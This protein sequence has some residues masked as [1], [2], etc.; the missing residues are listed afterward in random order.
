M[1]GDIPVGLF[2][3]YSDPYSLVCS[4]FI[5]T[6]MPYYALYVHPGTFRKLSIISL[7]SFQ[8][9]SF[10]LLLYIVSLSLTCIYTCTL[11]WGFLEFFSLDFLLQ[12]SSTFPLF[13]IV[14]LINFGFPPAVCECSP[15]L[16]SCPYKQTI[17]SVYDYE[18][19][20]HYDTKELSIGSVPDYDK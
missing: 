16:G 14:P 19:N 5:W 2:S 12:V 6:P 13:P 20:C 4:C 18:T 3:A 17:R 8:L 7:L 1:S 9:P 10:H 11:Q 15:R